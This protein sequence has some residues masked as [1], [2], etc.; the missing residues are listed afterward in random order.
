V[1]QQVATTLSGPNNAIPDLIGRNSLTR[2]PGCNRTGRRHE[3]RRVGSKA[4]GIAR[5]YTY[6]QSRNQA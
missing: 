1:T 4:S 6:S 5:R 2:N 3:F